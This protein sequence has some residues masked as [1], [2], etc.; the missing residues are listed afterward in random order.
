MTTAKRLHAAWRWVSQAIDGEEDEELILL[1][2]EIRS[3]IY[4]VQQVIL[5]KERQG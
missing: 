3:K 1:M 4:K 2:R 5:D